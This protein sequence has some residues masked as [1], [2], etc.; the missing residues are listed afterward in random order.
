MRHQRP[1]DTRLAQHY[2]GGTIPTW[3]VT[4]LLN[5]GDKDA[6]AAAEESKEKEKKMEIE[7]WQNAV[8]G[9]VTEEA[10]EKTKEVSKVTS[11]T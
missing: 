5:T 6:S 11:I 7:A 4:R 10:H 2:L 3:K 1:F 9:P 8:D